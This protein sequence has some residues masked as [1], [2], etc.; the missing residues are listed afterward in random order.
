[1]DKKIC[2]L[3]MVVMLFFGMPLFSYTILAESTTV[4]YIS[5]PDSYY[6]LNVPAVMAPGDYANITVTGRWDSSMQISVTADES[7]TLA[8]DTDNDEV[9]LPIY[10]E[11]ILELGN[12]S[13]QV[14]VSKELRVGEI[15]DVP[16][17]IWEG[18]FE[19]AVDFTEIST[20]EEHSGVIPVGGTYYVKATGV[21][22]TTFL[23]DYSLAEETLVAGDKFPDK[24]ND[25][26]AYV[27]GGY[28][29]RYNSGFDIGWFNYNCNGWG[30]CV[31]DIEKT[32]Y[33]NM[34]LSINGKAITN[35]IGTYRYCS[36]MEYSPRIPSTVKAM[37]SAYRDCTSLVEAPVLHDGVTSL[38][39]TF[40]N[41]SLLEEAPVLPLSVTNLCAAFELCH[42]LKTAP[43]IHEN[44]TDICGA[45]YECRL[46]TG[47]LEI[48]SKQLDSYETAI[49]YTNITEITG[50]ISD[51]LKVAILATK[52]VEVGE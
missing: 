45:F 38:G 10:F 17:G 28:E 43:V 25:G 48:N 7:V 46:L 51:E 2:S 29:Y 16:F 34:L 36:N 31:L 39:F 33:E 12:D 5:N 11:E 37:D 35:M 21:D 26:D 13:S 47:T 4:R 40:S 20:P 50:T 23:S 6:E 18:A 9:T 41:C 22:Y 42:N 30:V 19:Y 8:N 14:S 1:M 24:I 49:T 27:Y 52:T 15:G 32:L 3:L 44:I